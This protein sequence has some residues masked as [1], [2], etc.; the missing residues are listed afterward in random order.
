MDIASILV[1]EY[2]DTLWTLNGQTFDGLVWYSDTPKPTLEELEAVWPKVLLQ[3]Q[4]ELVAMRREELYKAFTDK[5]FL[6]V[7]RGEITLQDWVDAVNKIKA[8]NPYPVK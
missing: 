4:C 1:R 8:D 3:I 5:M 7:Q 2:P 6:Q